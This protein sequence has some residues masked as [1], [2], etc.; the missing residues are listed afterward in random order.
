MTLTATDVSFTLTVGIPMLLGARPLLRRTNERAT[1]YSDS[2]RNKA[3]PAHQN[4]NP[5]LWPSSFVPREVTALDQNPV[6]WLP[7]PKAH[8]ARHSKPLLAHAKPVLAHL[9]LDLLI[10]SSI[11]FLRT[12]AVGSFAVTNSSIRMQILSHVSQ[13][14][15][16]TATTI[17]SSK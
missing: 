10:S 6:Q 9:L 8:S 15:V 12:G 17:N 1:P 7:V 13:Q 14:F 3:R 5:V 16:T 2:K 4:N 11:L